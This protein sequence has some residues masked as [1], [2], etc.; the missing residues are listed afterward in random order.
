M[1]D[2]DLSSE[3]SLGI[4][5]T[6]SVKPVEGNSRNQNLPGK[7]RRRAPAGNTVEAENSADV[8]EKP[9]HQVDRLA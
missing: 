8:P 4:L 9:P 3:L 7:S 6:P 1:T 2:N 5:S